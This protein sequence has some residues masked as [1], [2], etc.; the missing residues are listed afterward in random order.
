[1]PSCTPSCPAR[2]CSSYAFCTN[3]AE[4][5]NLANS[6]GKPHFC[7][8]G[9]AGPG[10]PPGPRRLARLG[11]EQAAAA[12]AV[13]PTV[14]APAQRDTAAERRLAAAAVRQGLCG[15]AGGGLPLVYRPGRREASCTQCGLPSALW[16]R[17]TDSKACRVHT[18][19]TCLP[20]WVLV[21]KGSG[22]A[23]LFVSG[24]YHLVVLGCAGPLPV[25]L[26]SS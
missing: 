10:G 19:A 21:G 12:A 6:G 4:V 1:M 3:Y 24:T 20:A 13:P 23:L 14:H 22:C 2:V 26:Q 17:G 8:A 5:H 16:H 18:L 7:A 25:S 11:A 9:L 15:G